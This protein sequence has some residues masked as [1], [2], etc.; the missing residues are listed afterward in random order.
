MSNRLS[1]FA[2]LANYNLKLPLEPLRIHASEFLNNLA[3]PGDR[4]R[5]DHMCHPSPPAHCV[6]NGGSFYRL[7]GGAVSLT[8][9]NPCTIML[10]LLYWCQSVSP[11]YCT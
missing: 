1:V 3:P 11:H 8:G 9:A 7:G 5:S 4:A 2:V 6:S 10:R